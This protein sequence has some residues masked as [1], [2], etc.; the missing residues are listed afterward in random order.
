MASTRIRMS[1]RST[2]PYRQ[3]PLLSD[4]LFLYRRIVVLRKVSSCDTIVHHPN[5]SPSYTHIL[6]KLRHHH[7]TFHK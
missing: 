3:S 6:E 4:S 2:G 5:N 1:D 7:I